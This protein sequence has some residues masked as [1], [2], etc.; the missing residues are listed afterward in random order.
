M[1]KLI[2]AIAMTASAATAQTSDEEA[3]KVLTAIEQTAECRAMLY[4]IEADRAD[5]LIQKFGQQ[6]PV[7][8]ETCPFMI[9]VHAPTIADLESD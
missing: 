7:L 9:K 1:E 4:L 5:L 2:F 3:A 6:A 8:A